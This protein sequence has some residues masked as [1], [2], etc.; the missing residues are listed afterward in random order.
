MATSR[1]GSTKYLKNRSQVLAEAKASGV[2]NCPGCRQVLNYDAPLQPN[3]AETDHIIEHRKGG[4]D[5]V[6]NLRVLCRSCNLARN[7]KPS[8]F[9]NHGPDQ[10]P[11]SRGW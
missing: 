7:A 4:S 3:S 8:E 1:T 9:T 11:M 5:E 2:T 10:F 6:E